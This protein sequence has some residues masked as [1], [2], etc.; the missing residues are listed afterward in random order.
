M[1]DVTIYEAFIP[2]GVPT[3]KMGVPAVTIQAGARW[4]D[5][6]QKVTVEGR[7]YV[8]GGGCTSVGAAGGF[9]QRGGFGSF[10]RK[11]GL[12]AA[13]LLEAEV[14]IANGEVLIANEYQNADLFWALK[15]GGGG[16]FGIVSKVT[17]Q[18]YEL[19]NYFGAVEGTITARTDEA[20]ESLIKYFINFYCKSLHNEHWGGEQ[21]MIKPDN[22]LSLCLVF[23]GLSNEEAIKVWL[24]FKSWLEEQSE[25]Y[26]F[27]LG[28]IA[29]PARKF[30]DYDYWIQN[31]PDSIKLHREGKK[32]MLYWAGDQKLFL[33][34]WYTMKS[35]WIPLSFFFAR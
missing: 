22:S 26:T 33:A 30:W 25:L 9:L 15:G 28:S 18:T 16:T 23:Q 2:A 35:R 21:V 19:P 4:A 3:L 7:R 34:Y 13:S 24:P 1:R 12:A 6:Y 10:S 14:V 11:Y 5:V 31:Y 17:L 8:Q 20:F 27:T 29:V 32:N